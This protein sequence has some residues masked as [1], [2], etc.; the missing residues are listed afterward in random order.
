MSERQKDKV[1]ER[2]RSDEER[3]ASSGT[4]RA[5]EQEVELFGDAVFADGPGKKGST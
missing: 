4:M 1:S 3:A 2:W 5:L